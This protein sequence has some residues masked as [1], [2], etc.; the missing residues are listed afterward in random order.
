MSNDDLFGDEHVKRYRETDGAEG[1]EWRGTQCLLLTTIGRKS[2]QART[3]PLIFG[4]DG[5]TPVI[6]ASKG[7]APQHPAW[8][9]NLKENPEVEVQIKGEDFTAIARDAEGEERSKLWEMMLKE[10][11]DYADYQTKTDRQIPV[12]VLDRTA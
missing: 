4:Y 11:P 8:Y 1:Y 6:V 3:M 9:L 5:D 12:V 10:W 7:G 2:K